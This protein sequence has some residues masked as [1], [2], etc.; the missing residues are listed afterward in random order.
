M[1]RMSYLAGVAFSAATLAAQSNVA[2][3]LNDQGLRAAGQADFAGAERLY[4]EALQK[5]RELGSAYDAHAAATLVNLG[6]ALCNEEKWREGIDAFE[7]GLA[8]HRRSLGPKHLRTVYN[9]SLLGHAYV[10]LAD[11]DRA[12]ADL[13]EALATG[14]ELYPGDAVL[15]HTLMG[16]SFLRRLQGKLEESLQLGEEGLNAAL[17]AGGEFSTQAGMAYENVGVIHRLAGR[18]ERALPLFRKARFIYQQTVG[19]ASPIFLSLLSQEGLALLEDGDLALAERDMLQAVKG[20]AKMSPAF[21]FRLATSESNLGLLRFRQRKFGD[22]E[23]LLTHALSLEDHLPS[24]P[25]T[26]MAA[27]MGVLAQ[28]RRA[29]Q[30]DAESAQLRR[31]AAELQAGH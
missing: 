13:G 8:L 31:R 7:E 16:L 20:L 15:G 28:L 4:G 2:L 18:P 24:P 12:E 14:R 17:K 5:W 23:R 29:Q 30:R 27:T 19:P 1:H 11:R 25:V 21:D 3:K 9:L 10:Q 6:Q 22:A 26:D